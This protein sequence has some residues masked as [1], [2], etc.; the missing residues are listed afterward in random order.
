MGKSKGCC[1]CCVVVEPG[2]EGYRRRALENSNK[3]GATSSSS[4]SVVEITDAAEDESLCWR[5]RQ[6]ASRSGPFDMNV[7]VVATMVIE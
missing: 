6:V 2:E 4:F 1:C 5:R 3:G 7:L